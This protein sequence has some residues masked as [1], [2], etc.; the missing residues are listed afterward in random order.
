MSSY[1]VVCPALAAGHGSATGDGVSDILLARQRGKGVLDNTHSTDV[2]S[3]SRVRKSS[4]QYD[5][6]L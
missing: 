1:D 5:Y 3:T 6:S 2:K 4:S